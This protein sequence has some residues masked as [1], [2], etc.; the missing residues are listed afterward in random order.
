MDIPDLKTHSIKGE[1]LNQKSLEIAAKSTALFNKIKE[2]T[3]EEDPYYLLYFVISSASAAVTEGCG[4]VDFNLI[5]SAYLMKIEEAIRS[6]P[7]EA[8]K[9]IREKI[10]YTLF[11]MEDM[12]LPSFGGVLSVQK[13]RIS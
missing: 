11:E 7:I 6:V 5:I 2:A 9:E 1:R 8:Q 4:G 3:G 13:D 10:A 12:E